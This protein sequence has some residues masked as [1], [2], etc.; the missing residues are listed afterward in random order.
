[1][2]IISW[3]YYVS[4][5][6]QFFSYSAWKLILETEKTIESKRRTICIKKW[7]I[8]RM[9]FKHQ[10]SLKGM[11]LSWHC[12]EASMIQC[13]K[14]KMQRGYPHSPWGEHIV[15]AAD[16]FV[17]FGSIKDLEKVKVSENF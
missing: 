7:E 14:N 11:L 16:V 2:E 3:K 1:M 13:Q 12:K 5:P 6:Q 4:K 17:C 8:F 10:P 15:P 9:C